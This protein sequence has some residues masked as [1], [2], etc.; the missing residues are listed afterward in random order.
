VL[1]DP[2]MAILNETHSKK[3]E[4]DK[5][6]KKETVSVDATATATA[7]TQKRSVL[8]SLPSL[9]GRPCVLSGNTEIGGLFGRYRRSKEMESTLNL[10]VGVSRY[11][12][13]LQIWGIDALRKSPEDVRR[14]KAVYKE[15]PMATVRWVEAAK[16]K[17]A[18]SESMLKKVLKKQLTVILASDHENRQP[19]DAE[20]RQKI[21]Q[22]AHKKVLKAYK[23]LNDGKKK[24]NQSLAH[25]VE[26]MQS[27]IADLVKKYVVQYR[28]RCHGI[29]PPRSKTSTS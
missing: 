27:K 3:K 17:E 5:K 15:L 6:V 7:A 2:L 1:Y 9:R 14:H 12:A 29:N 18:D 22:S 19:F 13:L 10:K 4:M 8:D 26:N 24:N 21:L 11:N 20:Q 23:Q 16:P 25:F 28:K